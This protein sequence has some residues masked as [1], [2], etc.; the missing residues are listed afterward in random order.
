MKELNEQIL[1]YIDSTKEEYLNLHRELAVIPAPSG[2]EDKRVAFIKNWFEKAGAKQVIVDD[3]KNVL[4]PIGCE[5]KDNIIVFMAHTDVV[6]PDLTDLPFSEDDEYM[7]CPGI[8]DDTSCL[9]LLMMVAKY[10]I[11][12]NLT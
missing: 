4:V 7:Y 12:N 8:G 1:K 11:Q 3:A 6:F 9:I 2:L 10:V 5:N